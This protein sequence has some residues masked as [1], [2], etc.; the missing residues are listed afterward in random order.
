MNSSKP[1]SFGMELEINQQVRGNPFS[2]LPW[3]HYQN[4]EN[5]VIREYITDPCSGLEFLRRATLLGHMLGFRYEEGEDDRR[6]ESFHLHIGRVTN[7]PY[8]NVDRLRVDKLSHLTPLLVAASHMSRTGVLWRDQVR[9][10]DGNAFANT[11]TYTSERGSW[12]QNNGIGTIE[13]RINENPAPLI[14]TI[15][16]PTVLDGRFEVDNSSMRRSLPERMASDV[17]AQLG[18]AQFEGMMKAAR[19]YWRNPIVSKLLSAFS[20]GAG[21][22]DVWELSH[23]ELKEKYV[24]YNQMLERVGA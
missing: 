8:R 3:A 9:M 1:Y 18:G 19:D 2:K 22:I 11:V 12:V 20:K 23:K 24:G 14:P 16:L 7:V 15:L 13:L 5:E 10:F 4:D 6:A 21:H 17:K